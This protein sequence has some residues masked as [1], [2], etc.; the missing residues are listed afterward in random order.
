[1]ILNQEIHINKQLL[2][3]I[4]DELKQHNSK[5]KAQ[6]MSNAISCRLDKSIQTYYNSLITTINNLTSKLDNNN[7]DLKYL[8]QLNKE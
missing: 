5:D 3:N 1:M 2:Y 4:I 6:L 8:K 7:N